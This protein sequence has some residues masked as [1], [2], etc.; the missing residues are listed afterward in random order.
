MPGRRERSWSN[1]IEEGACA[2][3]E[4]EEICK[5]GEPIIFSSS[6]G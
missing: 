1:E 6:G 5:I 4:M 2:C 3:P